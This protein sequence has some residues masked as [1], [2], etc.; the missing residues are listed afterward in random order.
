MIWEALFKGSIIIG[1]TQGIMTLMD[2]VM[3]EEILPHRIYTT[4]DA[5]RLLSMDRPD[6]INL[7]RSKEIKGRLVDGNYRIAGSS[8]LEYIGR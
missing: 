6:V 5:A 7:L 8:I 2:K 3:A 1:F 4:A